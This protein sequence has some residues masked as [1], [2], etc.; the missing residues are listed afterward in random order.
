MCF[1]EI[2][3]GPHPWRVRFREPFKTQ[4]YK[5]NYTPEQWELQRNRRCQEIPETTIITL[6][7]MHLAPMGFVPGGFNLG[8]I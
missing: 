8:R 2:T 5:S 3:P 7:W 6:F 1:A 4:Q